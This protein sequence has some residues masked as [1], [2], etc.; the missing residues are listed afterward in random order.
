[1]NIHMEKLW[2]GDKA[3]EHHHQQGTI[4]MK[5]LPED[6]EHHQYQ[7]TLETTMMM[8]TILTQLPVM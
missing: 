2:E 3:P 4:M 1:M 7:W 6:Q 8:S 5:H